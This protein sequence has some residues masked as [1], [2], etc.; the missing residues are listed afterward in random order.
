[1]AD[2]FITVQL[3]GIEE[4]GGDVRFGEFI[5]EL[6]AVRNALRQTQRLVLQ[7]DVPVIDYR[8]SNLTHSSPATVTIGIS[9]RDPVYKEIPKRISRRFTS[10]LAVV[11]KNHRYAERLDERT[12]KT[13]QAIT[14]PTRKHISRVVVSDEKKVVQ[15]DGQFERSLER[16]ILGDESERDELVGRVERVDIHN[17]NQ[18]D[19]YPAV[20]PERVRCSAPRHL[21]EQVMAAIGRTVSVAG[22]ALYRK[23]APFPYAMRVEEIHSHRSDHDLP[24]MVALH[25]IAPDATDGV[26]GEDFIRKLRNAYW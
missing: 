8:I 25:G 7:D 5:E 6:V 9:T 13:F 14:Q 2:A 10:S 3:E 23:D 17:K 18:F 15:I 20:G 1:M 12:L 24:N 19:V 22:W 26:S 21:Q 4:D 11:R 16:L